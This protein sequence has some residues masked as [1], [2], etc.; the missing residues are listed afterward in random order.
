M[1]D[2]HVVG[3]GPAGAVCAR[4][5]ARRGLKVLV[6]EEHAKIGE[7]V[8]C[9]GLISTGGL[10]ALGV[11]YSRAVAWRIRGAR[12]YS[13][14][15]ESIRVGNGKVRACVVSRAELDSLLAEA[16]EREGVEIEL[17]RRIGR[18]DLRGKTVVGADGAGSSV[19]QWFGFPEIREFVIGMQVD[20]EGAKVAEPDCLDMFISNERFPGFFGWAIPLGKESVRVGMGAYWRKG[21]RA[22]PVKALFGQFLNSSRIAGMLE[23]AKE[24]SRLAGCIPM[25]VRERT[26][27]GNT[28]LVGD[29]AG[30]VKATT[31]GGV[32]FGTAAAGM[33]AEAIAGGAGAW[34]GDGLAR[35]AVANGDAAQ[36]YET[37]WRAALG[38]DLDAHRRIRG[39]LNS[40]PDWQ[41]SKLFSAAK[42]LGAEAFLE[43]HGDM[44]KPTGMIGALDRGFAPLRVLGAPLL[45]D[46]NITA[47]G[48]N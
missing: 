39:A 15:M 19:A 42:L 8:Q 31:G 25:A 13:P 36:E 3:A 4:E 26:A 33:A 7:P 18:A 44:D 12:V 9:S 20:Y 47:R 35:G 41:V 14:S 32:V 22:A 40:M 10:G 21:E 30:Q 38:G 17:G 37:R 28:L 29:A 11:D 46:T 43:R 1:F 6:S 16:A 5:C 34:G 45:G 48:G 27:K 2:V 23:G 24:R